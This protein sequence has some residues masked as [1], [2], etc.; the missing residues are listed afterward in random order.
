[1]IREGAPWFRSVMRPRESTI[2]LKLISTVRKPFVTGNGPLT[3]RETQ[4]RFMLMLT[5]C[6]R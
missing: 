1:M 5:H 3:N 4:C 2:R 6:P